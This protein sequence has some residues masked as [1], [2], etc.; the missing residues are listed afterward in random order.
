M[1]HYRGELMAELFFQELD[2]VF[3]TRPTTTDLGYDLLVGF[4]NQKSGINTFAVEVKSTEHTPKSHFPMHRGVFDRLAHSN[5]P[6]LLLVAEV[7][8]RR[9]YYAWL[10][11]NGAK[12]RG[13]SI[14]IPLV[15][16]N[17]ATKEELKSQFHGVA[18]EK[19]AVG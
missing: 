9:L 13:D 14:S 5:I 16:I 1:A 15:E 17:D 2:P 19:A 10:R 11:P 6:S 4:S 3:L 8:Q 7:K 18:G 12:H